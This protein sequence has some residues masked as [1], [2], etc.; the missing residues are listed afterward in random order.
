MMSLPA[1]SPARGR[2]LSLLASVAALTLAAVGLLLLP[3]GRAQAAL[4][5]P[6]FE[7]GSLSGWTTGATQEG[8]FVVGTDTINAGEGVSQAPL[9]GS[10]MARLGKPQ[11]TNSSTLNT[12]PI[13]QNE[14]IQQF[15]IDQPSVKFAYNIWTYDY[16]GFDRFS[17]ELRLVN[18][19]MVIYSYSQQAWG[20]SGDTARKNTGWQVVDIP[21]AQYQGQQ[22]R[23]KISAGGSLDQLY[24]FWA[25]IDSAQTVIP[26]QV[27]N[28]PGIQVNGYNPS[29]D[30]A[31]QTIN[32]TRPPG[33]GPFR[34]DIPVVC[35]NGST[36]VSVTVIVG[37]SPPISVPLTKGTG[38][39]WGGDIPTPPGVRGQSFPLTLVVNCPPQTI[40]ILIGSIT[41]VDPSGFITDAQTTLPIPEATVT[42]QRLD[43]ATWA[44]VNPFATNPD[45]SPQIAPQVNPELTD[46]TGHYAWDVIAGTYRV[47]VEK[48]GYA[49]RT[50][51]QVTVPPPVLDLNLAL[52]PTA[53]LRSGDVDCNSTADSIDALK[54]LLYLAH[55]GADPPCL[56]GANVDC[57]P[58]VD[59]VDALFILRHVALLS[60]VLP[61]GC[62]PIGEV[63]QPL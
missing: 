57:G 31:N 8:V 38:N 30:P 11:P 18:S 60:V 22:A 16:T 51:P 56:A 24:A 9:E 29:R 19:D 47:V 20:A 14:L 43:G 40:T 39:M 41:L 4:T 12:Q 63:I 34:L 1:H 27:V 49:S 42:L 28:F 46:D 15:T 10:F 50:S 37:A 33:L 32:V 36:P 53:Q 61:P 44:T 3:S 7:T 13:G 48:T 62:T 54:V 35:P 23:L 21:A 58:G 52:A 55:I 26:P 6:G 25:Y 5:N 45:A 2:I 59:S 17:I